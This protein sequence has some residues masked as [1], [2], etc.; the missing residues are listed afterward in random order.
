M[1]L[2]SA[3]QHP[4]S[5]KGNQAGHSP[6]R[7]SAR[8]R[9]K[10]G[11]VSP[12]VHSPGMSPGAEGPGRASQGG[13]TGPPTGHRGKGEGAVPETTFDFYPNNPNNPSKVAII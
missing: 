10:G 3:R 13:L 5:Q 7:A 12:W 4:E 2:A 1:P 8:W 9:A 6:E 11:A